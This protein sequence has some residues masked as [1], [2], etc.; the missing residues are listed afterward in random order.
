[1][2]D[3]PLPPDSPPH[4]SYLFP[5]STWKD[6]GDYEFCTFISHLHEDNCLNCAAVVRHSD[7]YRLFQRKKESYDSLR[8]LVPM[9]HQLPQSAPVVVMRLPVR[10]VPVCPHCLD[11]SREGS[12][13]LIV[14]TEEMWN[15]ALRRNREVRTEAER[16]AKRSS[17]PRQ[18]IDPSE[19][20]F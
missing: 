5:P 11:A 6:A 14:S 2:T 1:M 17:T 15:E 19:I 20:P 13:H 18:T 3:V 8:R 4:H 9:T 12:L 10:S 7:I 16:T